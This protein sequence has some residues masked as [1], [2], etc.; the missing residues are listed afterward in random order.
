M[1]KKTLRVTRIPSPVSRQPYLVTS[2][3][4]LCCALAGAQEA[5]AQAYPTKPVRIISPFAAGGGNDALCRI[6][7]PKLSENLKQQVI[8]DNRPGAN[9]II[10]TDLAAK[11]PPDGYTIVLIPSGHAV[12]ASLHKKLPYD[13]IRD[14]APITLAGSSP[15]LVVVHPSVPAKNVKELAAL[16]KARPA[17]LTYVSAGIGSSGHLAG[18]LFEVMTGT[19]LVHVPYKGMG[20]SLPDLIGGHASLAFG[21]TLSTMPHV[22]SGRL[23]ALAVTGARRSPALPELPTVA[24]SGV[25]GYEASLWYGFVGPARLPAEIV[26]RLHA[27][28]AAVLALPDV[29]ERLASQGLDARSTTPDEF[30]RLLAADLDRWAGVVR[31][32]G[33]QAE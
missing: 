24:E 6:I 32:A 29:R 12:N 7:A 16:A 13:S 15:L 23:R 33:V 4:V 26:R 28:I 1:R 14:F 30:A 8:V 10:G 9:G 18:A 31:R 20:Q 25:P 5:R 19:K 2:L 22:R 27:E 21:T 11:S 3:C 17:Q